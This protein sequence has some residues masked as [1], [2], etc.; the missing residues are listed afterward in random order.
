MSSPDSGMTKLLNFLRQSDKTEAMGLVL[1]A[2]GIVI[3][4]FGVF[5]QSVA[6]GVGTPL[7]MLGGL[8]V[9]GGIAV[10]AFATPRRR[11]VI[12]RRLRGIVSGYMSSTADW[13]WMNRYGLGAVIVGLVW[14]LPVLVLQMLFGQVAAIL[15][16]PGIMIFFGGIALLIYGVYQAMKDARR[17]EDDSRSSKTS[18]KRQR[19]KRFWR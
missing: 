2:I 14:L 3:L 7:R 8:M 13:R 4:A 16:L 17:E 10:F 18:E 11:A 6:V 15:M 5:L 9:I 12:S 1:A 19:G